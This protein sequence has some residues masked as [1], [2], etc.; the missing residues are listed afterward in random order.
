[1]TYLI[2]DLRTDLTASDALAIAADHLGRCTVFFSSP[3]E[4]SVRAQGGSPLPVPDAVFALR[5]FSERGEVT[6]ELIGARTG[7]AQ[8]RRISDSPS[9]EGISIALSQPPVEHEYICWG[10]VIER[11]GDGVVVGSARTGD[12]F[13]PIDAELGDT[14]VLKSVECVAVNGDADGNSYV[15]G[16]LLVGLSARGG[17]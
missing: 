7:S 1:M 5:A 13:L 16:E 14:V 10:K 9:D 17:L 8:V 4:F 12:V 6:W 11:N 3:T 2:C 15:A